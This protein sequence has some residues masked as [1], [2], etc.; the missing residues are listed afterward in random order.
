MVPQSQGTLGPHT[1][2][3]SI[4]CSIIFSE[5]HQWPEIYSLSKVFQFWEKPEVSGHQIWARECADSPG[6]FDVLP[7]NSAPDMMCERACCHDEA[8]NHWLAIAVAF[9]VI[10]IVSTE[11]CSSLI[12][13]LMQICCSIRSVILTVM[14]TQYTRSLNGIYHLHWLVQWSHHC[15]HMCISVHSPW[16]PGYINVPQTILVILTMAGLL[17]YRPHI[18]STHSKY[19]SNVHN[20]INNFD[21]IK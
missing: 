2:P 9:W 15:S 8:V 6:W 14:A 4:S 19:P 20:S 12:Q 18:F 1:V 16:L 5:S 17:V 13:N 11:E 10:Q 7:K 3:I 21:D